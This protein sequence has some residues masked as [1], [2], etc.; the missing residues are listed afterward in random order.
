MTHSSSRRLR[1]GFAT[2]EASGQVLQ[3]A[4]RRAPDT[5]SAGP[6]EP[7]L[8]WVHGL[9]ESVLGFE[10]LLASPALSHRRQVAIDLPGYGRS[11]WLETPLGLDEHAQVVAQVI[12]Q[13]TVR[14]AA[15]VIVIG[16]SMGGVIGTLLAESQCPGLV[17]LVNL[18]GNIS[19][20][21]CVQSR[22]AVEWSAPDFEHHGHGAL[23]NE[24]FDAA[25]ED[26]SHRSYWP[27]ARLAD[28]RAF[29]RNASELVELSDGE[30]LAARFAALAVPTAFIHGYP[31]GLAPR[32][33]E[34][35]QAVGVRPLVV[36]PA[37]HW[38][39]ID[40]PRDFL[41]VLERALDAVSAGG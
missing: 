31:E 30:G 27:S 21:D 25:R 34:L 1:S 26:P 29:Y 12:Q 22:R 20:G 6:R 36:E 13:E 40:R 18:E 11:P 8:L 3:L 38:P 35:L 23:L 5:E 14:H 19:A 10:P 16:H 7:T 37:G 39:W 15:G 32:S 4:T 9:G 2:A 24:F 17:G 41:A 33:I 28:P